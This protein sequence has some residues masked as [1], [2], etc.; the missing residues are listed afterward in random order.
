M[1]SVEDELVIEETTA[2]YVAKQDRLAKIIIYEKI[3]EENN[4]CG[5]LMLCAKGKI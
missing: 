5:R 2:L 1:G 3:Y 4:R